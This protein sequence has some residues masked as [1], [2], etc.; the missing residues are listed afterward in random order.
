MEAASPNV[1]FN[2]DVR[3]I[4]AKHCFTCHGPDEGAREADLRLD[5]QAGS[6]DDLGG[7]AA[8][9]PGSADES[10]LIVRINSEDDDVRM[11][12]ADSHPPLSDAE[13]QTLKKWIN[14]GGEYRTHWSFVAAKDVT[15]RFDAQDDWSQGPIDRF[16][17][18][19][20]KDAGLQPS[21]RA[22]RE[23]LIR[24]LYFDLLGVTPTPDDVHRFIG[25][26]DPAAY[27]KLVDRLLASPDYAERF[28]RS[29]LDLARYSDT[30]GYEKDRPRTIWPYRDWV[31]GAIAD[32]MPFDQF[33]IEQLA[34]DMLAD[35]TAAQRIAT[36]FNRNTMLNEEGGIDPLEYRYY[37]MVDRVATVGTVWMGLTTGCAQC[38]THKYD[39]I[40]HTDYYAMMALM[41]NADEP[42]V[43]VPDETARAKRQEIEAKI[44]A[45]VQRIAKEQLPSPSEW[46]GGEYGDS[47]IQVAFANWMQQQIKQSR[48][49]R[50]I[51]PDEMSSTMPK[52]T[53][54]EDDSILA[55]GDVTKRDVYKLAFELT[56]DQAPAIALRL[57]VLAHDSLPA[58]GPG[59]GFYE[60]RRGDFFLSELKATLDGKSVKLHTASHS[61]GKI[62]VGSGSPDATN[63][64]DGDGSTGWSTSTMEGKDNQLVVNFSEP[65]KGPGKLAIELLFERHFAAPL[66]RFR[67]ALTHQ[68]SGDD[69][70]NDAAVASSLRESLSAYLSQFSTEELE[71][72][73]ADVLVQL[74]SDFVRTAPELKEHRKKIVALEKQLPEAVRTLGMQE[75]QPD[76]YR[77]THLHH[78][79]EYLQTKDPVDAAV[80]VV[81]GS[82]DGT[83][84]RLAFARW[85]VSDNNVLVGR[86]TANRA[87]RHFFGTGI[88]RTAG[89]FGTQSEPPSHPLLIDYLDGQLRRGGWSIKRLHR[90]I[91]L[92]ATYQQVVG[93]DPESD[94]GNR[95][96]SRF[97]YR[98]LEAEQIRDV[99][100]SAAD[101]LTRKWGGPS[102]YPPQPAAVS[103]MAYGNPSWD[104]S[105]GADRY[106]RSLYTFSKRTAPFAAFATFDGPSGETC[107]A[108]RDSST[109]PLQA[110][111]LM[112][113]DMY[114]EI[115]RG[116]AEAT[117]RDV[118]S[119][120]A[121]QLV[122]QRMFQRL[123]SRNPEPL[124]LD[125]TVAFY[126]S[127]KGHEEPWTLVARALMNTDEAIT[128]P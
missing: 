2:R 5:T 23:T 119:D 41:D 83:P 64:L 85:L 66:G 90:E 35:A 102:V 32:D 9:K 77:T 18:Q 92:S 78:R 30:N 113:D 125:A 48:D 47:A 104:T 25:D 31:I 58:G 101:L 73:D 27:T 93:A 80:P 115:A 12:P 56:G 91:V 123:L 117:L 39:P 84:N 15:V 49:W 116:L 62:S 96:L 124:E 75:R 81:F 29:W 57:E 13:I 107:L 54:L 98:R 60:G 43:L 65:L 69:T 51:R 4:L 114:L 8:V 121:P 53:L 44:D 24:R 86:V 72:I 14:E 89:D 103:Q 17:L 128:L 3:P 59:M 99:M 127:Q 61:F 46:A 42:D 94:P 67:V 109:T 33:T 126:D 97:P 74:Q 76:D 122:A 16:V 82:I 70:Q 19:R 22:S 21:A 87:W 45:E 6:R 108:R 38:H 106:R 20:M 37:A 63:V 7:Y 55:S 28:A 11:P 50:T 79:G 105:T 10:E 52:L 36:G 68:R 26:D 110:L 88:V 1:D 40:T 120:V 71:A 34:G 111:T 118:G 100:L 95:L 112:N